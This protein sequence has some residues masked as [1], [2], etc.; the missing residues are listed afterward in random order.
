M[1]RIETRRA[2]AEEEEDL[3]EAEEY[4]EEEDRKS[5]LQRLPSLTVGVDARPNAA[6][7]LQSR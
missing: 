4:E 6:S 7:C 5:L 1:A 3:I 2:E